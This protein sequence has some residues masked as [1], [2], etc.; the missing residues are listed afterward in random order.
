VPSASTLA[1]FAVASLVY[2]AVPGP[3]VIYIMTRGISQGRRAAVV[4]ALGLETGN[5]VHITAAAAGVSALL[6]SSAVAF[7]AA[8]YAGAAY[9]VCLGIK[10]LRG[11]PPKDLSAAGP[12][13]P[14]AR[15]G[16]VYRQG[17]LVDVFNPKSALFFLAFLPQFIDP[18]RGARLAQVLVL[19]VVV[20]VIGVAS[21]MCYALAAGTAGGWLGRRPRF[22]RRQHYLTGG[23]YLALGLTA[24]VAGGI[25]HNRAP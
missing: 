6:A 24:A 25:R 19:I 11:G 10:T 13:R 4:S 3:N 22:L 7:S 16:Q 18:G 20:T 21:D 1:A 8:R 14:R 12:E 5:L 23:I 2:A 9:L 15:L 17:I